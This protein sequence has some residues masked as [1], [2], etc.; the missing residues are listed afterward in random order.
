MWGEVER[1]LWFTDQFRGLSDLRG[2]MNERAR[3]SQVVADFVQEL[4]AILS[5]MLSN[6][7]RGHVPAEELPVAVEAFRATVEG[8]FVRGLDRRARRKV[9]TFALERLMSA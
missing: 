6:A 9:L 4:D 1:I 5:R 7:L 8:T 2:A 3:S